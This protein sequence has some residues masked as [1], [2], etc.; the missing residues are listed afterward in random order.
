VFSSGDGRS[1]LFLREGAGRGSLW[2]A[3]LDHADRTTAPTKLTDDSYDVRSAAWLGGDSIFT[4][5]HD[6]HIRLFTL[7]SDV[8]AI[9]LANSGDIGSFAVSADHSRIAFTTLIGGRWQLALAS[10]ANRRTMMLTSGDC[11]AYTPAWSGS[12]TILYAT[13]CGRG[14]G[15]TALASMDVPD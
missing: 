6:G 1:L 10:L 11:N 12:S 2:V 9:V 3:P 7:A 8:P 14:L 4:A 13:D 15:L 5:K